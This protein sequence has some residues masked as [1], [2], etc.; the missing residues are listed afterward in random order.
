M[1]PLPRVE[2]RSSGDDRQREKS[3]PTITLPASGAQASAL[4]TPALLIAW[5]VE[6]VRRLD[7]ATALVELGLP[8]LSF[9]L[10]AE[11]IHRF[12]QACRASSPRRAPA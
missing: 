3:Q 1:K 2:G 8:D 6:L 7:R 9:H 11:E 4:M 10:L 5:W 12:N